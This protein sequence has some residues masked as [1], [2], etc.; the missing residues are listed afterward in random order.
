MSQT[1]TVI[2]GDGIGPEVTDATLTI[3][4]AAGADLDYD[5]RL[6]GMT[7]LDQVNDPLPPDG[8]EAMGYQSNTQGICPNG[9]YLATRADWGRKSSFQRWS[10]RVWWSR[11]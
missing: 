4:R 1:I 7:A 8:G 5:V 6:A 3:L 11:G 10:E 2:P 9:W